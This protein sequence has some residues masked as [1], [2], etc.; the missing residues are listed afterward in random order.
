M[1]V[2]A[3]SAVVCTIV[4]F[5]A[6][7]AG[8]AVGMRVV[9]Q[10][11]TRVSVQAHS[12][13]AGQQVTFTTLNLSPGGDTVLHVQKYPD[14]TY[15]AGNDDYSGT[16]SQVT[17]VPNYTGL[18][19]VV[20]RA[21]QDSSYG[22][23]T[24]RKTVGGS[25]TDWSIA[26]GG[27]S[28]N[29]GAVMTNGALYTVEQ[30]GGANDTVI[31][32]LSSTAYATAFDDDDGFGNMAYAWGSGHDR[33]IIGTYGGSESTPQL[34]TLVADEYLSDSDGDSLGNALE[35]AIGTSNNDYDSDD[36]GIKD[37]E[38]VYGF[39]EWQ[40]VSPNVNFPF[41]GASPVAKDAFFE[42]DYFA[43]AAN[44][45]TPAN[46]T[47][48][49][50]RFQ[51]AG[52][53]AHLDI[54][55]ANADPNTWKIWGNW[56]G[57][58]LVGTATHCNGRTS[59][60]TNRF[61]HILSTGGSGSGGGQHDSAQ[62][63]YTGG[64]HP[65]T[66]THEN[67]HMAT[68]HDGFPYGGGSGMDCNPFYK[69][70]M[71]QAYFAW[72]TYTWFSTG[73]WSTTVQRPT[74][75][76]ETG[77]TGQA[78]L[79][80]LAN[81]PWN[82]LVDVSTGK[83]D[84]NR[85]SVF[86]SGTVRAAPTILPEDCDPSMFSKVEFAGAATAADSAVDSPT[87]AWVKKNDPVP[88]GRLFL[89]GRNRSSSVVRIA[90]TTNGALAAC[91]SNPARWTSCVPV[92]AW[93]GFADVTGAPAVMGAP[94]AVDIGLNRLLLVYR[95]QSKVLR[96]Q[97]GTVNFTT[98]AVGW[99]GPWVIGQGYTAW[100]DIAMVVD[101]SVV[102]LFFTGSGGTLF[103]LSYSIS[104]GQWSSQPT[105]QQWATGGS[106]YGLYGV[107]AASGYKAGDSTPSVFL[108]APDIY[109]YLHF[110]WR[111]GTDLWHEPP[112]FW[113]TTQP[114]TS[115]RPSLAYAPSV[116]PRFYFSWSDAATFVPLIGFTE[117]TD[118]SP[119]ASS[120]RLQA[121]TTPGFVANRWGLAQDGVSLTHHQTLDANLRLTLIGGATTF[122]APLADGVVDSALS[123]HD[124]HATLQTR[125]D[126]ALYS[127][128]TNLPACPYWM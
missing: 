38:E 2:R 90:S 92:S 32:A 3:L 33:V 82:F 64:Q 86:S 74:Q 116:G 94:A 128:C 7:R 88:S 25:S 20:V 111:V 55:T 51:A 65:Y 45:V 12:V 47:A 19:W 91:N 120:K 78:W 6:S 9:D 87:L 68:L 42:A 35:T 70:V 96:F 119:S 39:G 121:R 4:L 114:Q 28:V 113:V 77:W 104:T 123:D 109:G 106:V 107:A 29:L 1:N 127:C 100:D 95:D 50:Q 27:R 63:C 83:I 41:Y 37:N 89:L 18:V 40:G 73:S 59:S 124:D 11:A 48:F 62:P 44:M 99:T 110:G 34:T 108:L 13:T 101:G 103:E 24:L 97:V 26:F 112:G 79:P 57:S 23:C 84:W 115:A 36:D 31:L 81:A 43:S 56:G 122:F 93:S 5:A 67:G 61:H 52:I 117:G 30:Q 58:N 80:G 69:S 76:S 60:R 118:A 14:G 85:D 98:G 21:Y 102:R 75:M 71:N 16:A 46:A 10:P 8:A 72:S 54:G 125:L 15:I 49:A 17:F 126:C 53:S 105:T 22:T 66:M